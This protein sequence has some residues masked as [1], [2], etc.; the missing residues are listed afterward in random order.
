MVSQCDR[1]SRCNKSIR[2]AIKAALR[3]TCWA[4]RG[5]WGGLS[6]DRHRQH[7]SDQLLCFK[8]RRGGHRGRRRGDVFMITLLQLSH[9]LVPLLIRVIR[10]Q[11]VGEAEGSPDGSGG[12]G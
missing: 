4:S 12:G 9:L 7:L 5:R 3:R 10:V 8:V 11:G 2:R 1:L 6:G